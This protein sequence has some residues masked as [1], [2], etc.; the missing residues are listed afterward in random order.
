M[1]ARS[2]IV[3]SGNTARLAKRL[4]I[5][6][7]GNVARQAKRIFVIDSGNVARLVY[8][9]AITN[10]RTLTAAFADDG[11]LA[12]YEGYSSVGITTGPFGGID[13]ATI[14]SGAFGSLTLQTL[15]IEFIPRSPQ[16]FQDTR[17][18]IAGYGSDPGA[19]NGFASFT[20]N[21]HTLTPADRNS[22]SFGSGVAT[23]TFLTDIGLTNGNFA[24]SI[25]L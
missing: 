14:S 1:S 5:I 7:S 20:I 11:V 12:A 3:D 13:N 10:S 17:L 19:T 25:T 9:S 16:T 15:T 23:W 4:F 21:G 18:D 24:L 2:F 6:D 22:Y 8:V